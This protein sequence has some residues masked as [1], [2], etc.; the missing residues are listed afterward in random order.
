MLS[1]IY[2]RIR[3]HGE[4]FLQEEQETRVVHHRKQEPTGSGVQEEQSTRNSGE[5]KKRVERPLW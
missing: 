3:L 4:Q 5:K 2:K 1:K